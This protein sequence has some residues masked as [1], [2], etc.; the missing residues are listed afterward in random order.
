MPKKPSHASPDTHSMVGHNRP[1]YVI[2]LASR[3]PVDYG[4][5]FQDRIDA[6]H[7]RM[8]TMPDRIETKADHDTAVDIVADLRSLHKDIEGTR[9]DEKDPFLR[10]ERAVD[11]F[12]EPLK[13]TVT[14]MQTSVTGQVHA[15]LNR[16]AAEERA[17]REAVAAEERRRAEELRRQEDERRQKAEDARR[18]QARQRHQEVADALSK[19]ADQADNMAQ[20]ME[21]EIE[22]T[23]PADLARTR[24]NQGTLSTLKSEWVFAIE[25]LE[26]VPLDKLRPYLHRE[27]IEKAIRAFVR[28][29]GRE[30]PGVRIYETTSAIV[31]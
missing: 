1:D 28:V 11:G 23:K 4:D 12:F 18:A 2:E 8:R 6:I 15:Y 19:E 21:T 22:A 31:R 20:A 13:K 16:I 24:S 10:A 25:D 9:V 7:K 30:L 5:R 14:S 29:G 17:R 3:L 27:A 26:A